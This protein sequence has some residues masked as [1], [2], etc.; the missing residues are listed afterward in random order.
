MNNP[1]TWVP[2]P[3]LYKS[4]PYTTE[5]TGYDHVDGESIPRRNIKTK[6][7]LLEQPED[8]VATVYDI[9]R[10][11]KEK[12]GN[13]KALGYRKVVR[14]HDEVKKIKRTVDGK[15]QEEEKKWTYFE[16]SGYHYMT[17][18]E[19]ERATLQVG[20]GLRKLG[21]QTSDRLHI[22]AA[23]RYSIDIKTHPK[24]IWLTPS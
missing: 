2:Q 5:A 24:C 14:T 1:K 3:K 16:L 21:M 11:S 18:T 7:K 4:A 19:Y 15:E 17:F 13:A 8:G 6:D 10:K 20:A 23:T 12:F 22:F 9:L